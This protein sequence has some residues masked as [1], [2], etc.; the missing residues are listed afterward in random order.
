M[1]LTWEEWLDELRQTAVP[2][3]WPIGDP[4]AWREFY[5]DGYSPREAIEEDISNA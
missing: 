3:S 4:E 2:Y 1:K 5:N